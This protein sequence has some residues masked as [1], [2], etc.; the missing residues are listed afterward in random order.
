MK[1]L[2]PMWNERFVFTNF[3]DSDNIEFQVYDYDALSAHDL[4][5]TSNLQIKNLQPGKNDLWL[6]LEQGRIHVV[7][8][9]RLIMY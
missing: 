9:C 3:S 8:H 6:N 1:T 2:N 5:G 7:I 4:M